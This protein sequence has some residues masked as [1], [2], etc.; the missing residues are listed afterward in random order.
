MAIKTFTEAIQ[1][2]DPQ[3]A[4]GKASKIW[5]RFAQ[6][7]D[8]Y[9]ELSNANLIFHKATNLNFKSVE[10]LSMVYCSWAEM[11]IRHNNI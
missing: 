5:I 8:S 4:F 11:H 7:Y 9:D 10:E 1:T 6:F 2:I 3:E